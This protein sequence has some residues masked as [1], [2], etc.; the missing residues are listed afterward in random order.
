MAHSYSVGHVVGQE[1]ESI[2]WLPHLSIRKSLQS[3]GDYELQQSWRVGY[4][5]IR[6]LVGC[7]NGVQE[8]PTV[9]LWAGFETSLS[10][11][12]VE[13]IREMYCR[14]IPEEVEW[15]LFTAVIHDGPRIQS[16][17]VYIDHQWLFSS[18]KML[19]SQ[20]LL[21]EWFGWRPLHSSHKMALQTGDMSAVCW[22][23]EKRVNGS[24]RAR[25]LQGR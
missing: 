19:K 12:L 10:S 13:A 7:R 21:P 22:P 1:L 23:W 24:V 25:V 6:T 5:T 8:W 11:Y 2:T 20:D 15:D 17:Q 16:G 18:T 14:D 9:R 3:L 4:H